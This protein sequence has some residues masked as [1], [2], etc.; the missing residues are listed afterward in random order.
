MRSAIRG[1]ILLLLAGNMAAGIASA[2]PPPWAKNDK[3]EH[4]AKPGKHEARD[5]WR[6][7]RYERP[8][9]AGT[10]TTDFRDSRYLSVK[11]GGDTYRVDASRARFL[12]QS[13]KRV[14]R[15]ARVL[16]WGRWTGDSTLT[17]ERVQV[18]GDGQGLPCA[19][20]G[21]ERCNHSD[22]ERWRPGYGSRPNPGGERYGRVLEGRVTR[23]SSQILRRDITVSAGG[24]EWTVE[25]PAG[26]RIRR[27]NDGISVH[28]IRVG[29][30][31]RIEG[32]RLDDRRFRAERVEVSGSG[33]VAWPGNRRDND[34]EITYSGS[35]WDLARDGRSFRIR[36]NAFEQYTVRVDGSTRFVRDGRTTEFSRLRE[37]DRVRVKGNLDKR[38]KTLTASLVELL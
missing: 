37:G 3:R 9:L 38:D 15:N 10:V 21:E 24:T 25:V 13:D 8:A 35:A 36:L 28:D 22:R 23:A 7:N 29:E 12:G 17:A 26:I 2:A 27:G 16:V 33:S 11:S 14:R 1:S 32:Q 34:D 18:L 31:V 6:N 20:C 5:G 30:S 4:S 19:I